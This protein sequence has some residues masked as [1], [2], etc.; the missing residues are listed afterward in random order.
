[1]TDAEKI[2]VLREALSEIQWGS[3]G[4][5]PICEEAVEH[6]HAPDCLLR[7]VLSTTEPA[8]RDRSAPG[9]T[10]QPDPQRCP[11]CEWP[12]A[13]ERKDGCVPGDCSYRPD[14]HDRTDRQRLDRNR[15]RYAAWKKAQPAAGEG[16]GT[17]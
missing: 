10:W 12:Y 15:A 1:M 11:I 6:G 14:D 2:R 7:I 13:A 3:E 8:P 4:H 9:E 17:E 16:C 5:C